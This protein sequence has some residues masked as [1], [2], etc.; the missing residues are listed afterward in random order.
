MKRL[1]AIDA[2]RGFASILVMLYHCNAVVQSPKYFGD[3]PFGGFFGLGGV[4]MPFFFAMSGFMLSLVHGRDLGHPERLGRYLLG[5]IARIYPAY[6]VVL[7]VVVP[8]YWARPEFGGGTAAVTVGTVVRS[9]LLWPQEGVPYLSVAWTLQCMVLFYAVF[10]LAIWRPWVGGVVFGAW[11]VAVLGV[12][13]VSARP[14][15]PW[16]FLFHPLYLSLLLGAVAAWAWARGTVG[17][18][19]A[20][21]G[22]GGAFLLVALLLDFNGHALLP[23]DWQLVANGAASAVVLAGLAA[24]E[25]A[26]PFRVPRLFRVW[27]EASYAI[28]L[29][30]YPL[31][32]VLAKVGMALELGTWLSGEVLFALFA[33]VCIG[34]GIAFHRWVETPVT[35]WVQT[36]LGVARTRNLAAG[37]G[38]VRTEEARG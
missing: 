25:T 12:V 5:R 38:T 15:F 10:A 18:P 36:R 33:M 28:F 37:G 6:W 19:L 8:V 21:S 14:G 9:F 24:W 17:R 4:R 22:A 3:P 32:S 1:T 7:L 27:G 11:Q 23:F 31:L 13:A 16:S 2:A 34:A 35:L 26:T 29:V 20:W 30:H